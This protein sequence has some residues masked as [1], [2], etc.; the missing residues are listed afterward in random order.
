MTPLDH[1]V[2]QELIKIHGGHGGHGGRGG[3]GGNGRRGNH[4]GSSFEAAPS[5]AI[6]KM[7][8]HPNIIKLFESFED[9]RTIIYFSI[10]EEYNP[11]W[12]IFFRGV[13]TC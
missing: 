5:E 6:M 9:H 1:T 4:G 12:R 3:R 13:K 8:D 11:N 2:A 10:W 7:M